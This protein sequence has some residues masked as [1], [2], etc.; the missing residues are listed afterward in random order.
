MDWKLLFAWAFFAVPSV[1]LLALVVTGSLALASDMGSVMLLCGGFTVA[2]VS[3][4]PVPAV[5]R[6]FCVFAGLALWCA[7]P[8][9]LLAAGF[10]W[11]DTLGESTYRITVWGLAALTWGTTALALIALLWQWLKPQ[12]RRGGRE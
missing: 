1:V 4:A 6:W 7:A 2:G 9:V 10:T 8:A 11:S 5:V 12:R 3:L